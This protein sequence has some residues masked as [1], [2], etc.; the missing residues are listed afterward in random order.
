LVRE[1][2]GFIADDYLVL[3]DE[4]LESELSEVHPIKVGSINSTFKKQ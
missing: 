1:S 3:F 2:G 4:S